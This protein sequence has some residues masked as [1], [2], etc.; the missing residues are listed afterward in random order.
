MHPRTQFIIGLALLFSAIL[1]LK[2]NLDIGQKTGVEASLIPWLNTT[3]EKELDDVTASGNDY[4]LQRINPPNM[5][6]FAGLA[7]EEAPMDNFDVRER[8][9]REL[10]VNGYWHSNT[11][12]LFKLAYRHFPTVE[13]ILEREGVPDDF[14]YLALIESGFRPD[15]VS[16]A[17][18]EGFW[19]FL[20]STGRQFGLE[21]NNEVDERYH[22]EKS[23][24][25]AC[26]YLKQAKE[27]LGSWTLAAA[28]YN[29][30]MARLSN[31]MEEQH[32][33]N[34]YDLH[35]NPETDRYV[36]RILAIKE[37]FEN[38]NKYGF[39]L[40]EGDLYA[41]VAHKEVV[42]TEPI[43][44]LIDF[45]REHNT[46]YRKLKILNPWLRARHLMNT[47]DKEYVI[48]IPV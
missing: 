3:D 40:D 10:L 12:Q 29:V 37:I 15:A 28:S 26:K 32:V 14:K 45:A 22:L 23:T 7:G 20:S 24:V 38:P 13:S 30:G 19:Q 16:P 17:G 31:Q 35:L 41:T 1:L 47:G 42:V 34:Y 21:V 9:D 18:A 5:P 6:L 46:T 27:K 36:F 33:E 43:P 44:S 25:A 48:L 4:A 39:Y 8:L 11:L 2:L